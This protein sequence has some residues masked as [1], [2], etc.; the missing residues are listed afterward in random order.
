MSKKPSL[1]QKLQRRRLKLLKRIN[2]PLEH[3]PLYSYLRRNLVTF[4][5]IHAHFGWNALPLYQVFKLLGREKCK[6][7]VVQ[8]QGTDINSAPKLILEYRRQFLELAQDTRVRFT[9]N[10]EFMKKKDGRIG[11]RPE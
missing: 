1:A 4:D 7:L 11:N 9:A 5:L 3:L 6:P 8:C 10:S 2:V